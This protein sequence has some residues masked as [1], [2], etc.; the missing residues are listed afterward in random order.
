MAAELLRPPRAPELWHP[1]QPDAFLLWWAEAELREALGRSSRLGARSWEIF[2]QGSRANNTSIEHSS[3]IDLV[4]MLKTPLESSWEQFR[5]DVLAT[6]GES[7]TVRMGRRCLNVD[8]P[9]SLFGEMVDILVATEFHLG[10]EAG[11][12]FCD[13]D[14][15]PIVNFP[16]QHRRNGDAKDLRTGGRFKEAVRAAKRAKKRAERERMIAEGAAPSYLLECL[17]Y[18]VP[19]HLYR[20]SSVQESYR[21]ALRWLDRCALADLPCQNGVNRLFGPAPDQWEPGTAARI[22]DVLNEI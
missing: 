8:E 22:V 2:A 3:D 10:S 14:G 5:D 15:R 4:L 16:R 17:L 7:Y 1:E 19:D 13:I 21:E 11:V 12:F 20:R 6:L 18:N 9:D